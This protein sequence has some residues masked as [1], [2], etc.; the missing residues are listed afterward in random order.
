[1]RLKLSTSFFGIVFLALAFTLPPDFL[2][3]QKKYERVRDAITGKQSVL[4]KKLSDK[5]LSINNFNLLLI[6]YKDENKL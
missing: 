3:E 6:A 5:N 4:E 2:G 1:M